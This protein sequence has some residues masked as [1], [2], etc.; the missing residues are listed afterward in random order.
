M[1]ELL[2]LLNQS[3]RTMGQLLGIQSGNIFLAPDFANF[4]LLWSQVSQ[5]MLFYLSGLTLRDFRLTGSHF[6][7]STL[8]SGREKSIWKELGL[9]PG[10]CAMQ[11]TALTTRP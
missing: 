4:S 2:P 1:A 8:Y 6:F 3:E 5:L 10:P 7:P 9:N 11:V